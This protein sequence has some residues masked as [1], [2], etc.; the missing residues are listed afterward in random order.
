M[1]RRSSEVQ[2]MR[3]TKSF[4]PWQVVVAASLVSLSL[5]CLQTAMAEELL[6]S[7]ADERA[8]SEASGVSSSSTPELTAPWPARPLMEGNWQDLTPDQFP[9]VMQKLRGHRGEFSQ[10]ERRRNE[11]PVPVEPSRLRKLVLSCYDNV[12][13]IEAEIRKA[14]DQPGVLTFLLHDQGISMLNGRQ[15]VE[16]IRRLNIWNR[17]Q[18]HT[19]EQ[20]ASYL[21]FVIGAMDPGDGNFRVVEEANSIDWKTDTD[22]AAHADLEQAIRPATMT[23]KGHN[24]IGEAII[25]YKADLYLAELSLS[26]NG[27][28]NMLDDQPLGSDLPIKVRRFSEWIRYDAW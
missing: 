8:D 7:I 5:S 28:P 11:W 26:P 20:A 12:A 21:R 4:W 16:R 17:P 14:G 9:E 19:P 25:Q 24:W 3:T 6:P 27:Q 15:G 22:R 13:L 10:H 2:A 23:K 1:A 18:L